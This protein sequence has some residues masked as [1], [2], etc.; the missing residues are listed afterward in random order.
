MV[1]QIT[2]GLVLLIEEAQVA[3]DTFLRNFLSQLIPN[4]TSC[5]DVP[6]HRPNADP[7]LPQQVRGGAQG[8][9]N[10]ELLLCME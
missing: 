1:S 9:G 5:H 6:A 10:E 3:P 8:V 4:I 2:S 7:K